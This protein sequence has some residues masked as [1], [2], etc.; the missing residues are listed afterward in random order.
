MGDFFGGLRSG[1]Q[2][3]QVV[4]NQGPLPGAGGLPQPLHERPDARINYGS[5][6][7]GDLTPYAY[8]EPGYLSSQN[9]YLN[10]PHKIQKIV[11]KVF[12]PEA[13]VGAKDFFDLSHPVD[14]GDLA[15]V[16]RLD[17]SSLFCTGLKNGDMRRAGLGT[18]VDP[19]I[20]LCTFNYILSG[21]QLGVT[22]ATGDLW[23]EF[24]YNL[25]KQRFG[26][27]VGLDSRNYEKDP[28][29]LDDVMYVV[30]N[31]IRPFGITRGSEKQGGQNESTLSA[32]T[33][34]VSFIVSLTV[35]G[36][37]SNVL[38]IWH[39][40]DVHAGDDLVLR[41]K[42]MPIHP[43]TLNHYYKSV[44]RQTWD[45]PATGGKE[46]PRYVW[47][48]VP[49]IFNLE[50][51]K[52]EEVKDIARMYDSL[53]KN[54]KDATGDKAALLRIR[55]FVN[56]EKLRNVTSNVSSFIAP[57]FDWQ[58]LGFWHIG[59]SQIMTGKYGLEEYWHN[60]MANTL[61]TNHLDITIQPMFSQAPFK[62]KLVSEN[63]M[64]IRL[65]NNL[66][67]PL[68]E[69]QKKPWSAELSLEKMFSKADQRGDHFFSS[70][71]RECEDRPRA[72][73]AR[74]MERTS[75]GLSSE[76][77]SKHGDSAGIP[78]P[79]LSSSSLF[80]KGSLDHE[81]EWLRAGGGDSSAPPSQS[82]MFLAAE[83][84]A[85][86]EWLGSLEY[87]DDHPPAASVAT[88]SVSSK[89]IGPAAEIGESAP[90]S[91]SG[92]GKKGSAVT[93][94]QASGATKAAKRGRAMVGGS[95][96]KTDGTSEA[97]TVGML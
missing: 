17:R 88:P 72:K 77:T 27:A 63:K 97:S 35:D 81:P 29:G 57:N 22:G 85:E 76:S 7:L 52:G 73:S 19:L 78:I 55:M 21:L 56:S 23:S 9:A 41:L 74:T 91:S 30:R 8:G 36:K 11:P 84:G 25:D 61:R 2:F 48:L 10:I 26:K 90:G 51:P 43:Y 12:L 89:E 83:G 64:S 95:L 69:T 58:T 5:S 28:I 24:F 92:V 54:V 68:Q 66:A 4:M 16:L 59:R 70:K 46:H 34:P 6:L 79:G 20:N 13:K 15:F 94:T 47:Q 60:D 53:P 65:S 87:T 14:D 3:P 31:C 93:Q 37:E 1:I 42:L 82:T 45:L 96:L 80:G 49:D 38:N 71:E 75:A 40:H 86:P 62:V 44:K 67:Q 50:G 32:A 18:A 39:Y 33:W